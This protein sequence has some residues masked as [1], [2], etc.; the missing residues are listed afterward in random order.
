ME[1]NVLKGIVF[2]TVLLGGFPLTAAPPISP[3]G[4]LIVNGGF[5][6]GFSGWNGTYGLFSQSITP[7]PLSGNT[8]AILD[9]G[10]PPMTQ[11]IPTIPGLIYEIDLGARLPDLDGNGIPIVGDST[12]G[13]GVLSVYWNSQPVRSITTQARTWNIYT[14]DVTATG[15]SSQLAFSVPEYIF[16]GNSFQRSASIFLDNVSVT[17][18]VP[19]PAVAGIALLGFCWCCRNKVRSVLR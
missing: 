7:P 19:E 9:G 11:S 5:D 3:P 14:F 4:N 16:I 10:E 15:T 1:R 12:T 2:L 8:V 6:N 17:V 13:P 18:A